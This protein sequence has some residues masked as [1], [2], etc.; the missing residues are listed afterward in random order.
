MPQREGHFGVVWPTEKYFKTY[1]FGSWIKGWAVQNGRTSLN[2][3]YVL[4]R[5]LSQELRF[6]DRD[7]STSVK[8]FSGVDIF[9]RD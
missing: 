8:K 5:V 7:D 2:D 1:D 6:G 4:W 3:L 9:N